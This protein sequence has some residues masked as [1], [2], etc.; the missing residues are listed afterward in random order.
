MNESRG[1]Q[2]IVRTIMPALDL[3]EQREKERFVRNGSTPPS[4]PLVGVMTHPRVGNIPWPVRGCVIGIDWRHHSL[5]EK[6]NRKKG[7]WNVR[8][9]EDNKEHD[10]NLTDGSLLRIELA[11]D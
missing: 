4:H 7:Q 5:W 3:S 9:E 8:D 2:R 6:R 11:P 10:A 1:K